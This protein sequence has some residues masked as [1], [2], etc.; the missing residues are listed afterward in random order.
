MT[1][2]I[3]DHIIW[4]FTYS[5]REMSGRIVKN[6]EMFEGDG[7][8]ANRP[9]YFR[10]NNERWLF[11]VRKPGE[12]T[13]GKSAGSMTSEWVMADVDSVTSMQDAASKIQQCAK[14]YIEEHELKSI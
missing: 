5:E 14:K 6:N 7:T 1:L 10:G 8:I 11:G 2:K 12:S 9:W 13:V 4:N 3:G